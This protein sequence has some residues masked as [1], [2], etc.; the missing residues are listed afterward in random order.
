L[1]PVL[2]ITGMIGDL[3][4]SLVKRDSNAKDSGNLLPGLGGVWDVTDSLIAAVMPAFLCFVA[5]VA[6]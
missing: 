5:G 6:A 4:E 2:A 1:G 3:A